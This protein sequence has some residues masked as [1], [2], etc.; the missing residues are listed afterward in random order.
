[1]AGAHPLRWLLS[2]LWAAA[3]ATGAKSFVDNPLIGSKRLNAAG[4]HAARVR[5][6][7][8]MAWRRR[9]RLAGLATAEQRAAFARDGYILVRDFLPADAFARLRDGIA[10]RPL[11]AREMQQGDAITR[12]IAVD[13][14]AM[15]ALPELKALVADPRWRGL[16]RYVGSYDSEVRVY[17]QTILAG[18]YDA[19]ADPQ[20]HLHADTFHPTVKSWL[21]LTDVAEDEGPLTYV[22]GSHRITPER[23]AWEE[24]RSQTVLEKGDRLSQRGSLRIEPEQLAALGLPPATRFAVPAN[25]LIVADTSGFHA[26][27]ASARPSTRIE[28]WGY[29]RRNPFLP[30]TG[31]DLLSAPMWAHRRG[32]WYGRA[33]DRLQGWGLAGQPWRDVGEKLAGER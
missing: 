3:L 23:L 31:L 11:P 5:L 16:N 1:M 20:L 2:P 18:H 30:W 9:A 6:A 21:F 8:R 33:L 7:H 28:I 29:G 14:A 13:P 24:A 19:P 15:A 10:T 32:A 27:G 17:I 12:R 25:T 4:L 26:R 22:A